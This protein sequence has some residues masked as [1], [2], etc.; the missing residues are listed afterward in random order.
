MSRADKDPGVDLGGYVLA[1]GR[2]S[3]MGSDKALL[4]LGGK[5]LLQRV[6]DAVREAVGAVVIVGDAARHSR[7]GAPVIADEF[8]GAGPLAGIHVALKHSTNDWN[9]IVA[10]DMPG[11]TAATLHGLARIRALFPAADAVLPVA[12]GREQPLCAIYRRRLLPT[13]ESALEHGNLKI[14]R[15]LEGARLARIDFP[16]QEA[17]RNI[18]TPEEWRELQERASETTS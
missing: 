5:P 17:F 8:P 13:I 9:L 16:N 4:A 12:G 11:L 1:G 15:V 18:N 7:F 6:A 10:C 14:M 3:R 2:S